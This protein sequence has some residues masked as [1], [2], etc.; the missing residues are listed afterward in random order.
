MKERK[1]RATDALHATRA[2]VEEGIVP[3]GGTAYV[4][5]LEAVEKVKPR[6]DEEFGVEILRCALEEPTRRIAEN[7]GQ[8]GGEVVAE[9]AD[10]K[11]RVGFDALAG[12]YTDLVKAG[13]VDPAKVAIT[14]LRNAV[15]I[16]S[17]N[18]STNALITEVKKKSE[19]VAGAVS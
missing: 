2:A 18:L 17:L 9:V 3:G 8:D 12:E 11:G 14:A 7:A 1:D 4:R 13:V 15:S 5:A 6:G 19:P 16:A 10:R